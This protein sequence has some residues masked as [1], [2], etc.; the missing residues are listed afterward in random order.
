MGDHS[1]DIVTSAAL[2]QVL[3]SEG[4][5]QSASLSSKAHL[6]D[7]WMDGWR[8]ARVQEGFSKEKG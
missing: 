1:Q 2:T 4:S 8:N 7:N 3:R 6:M 5:K